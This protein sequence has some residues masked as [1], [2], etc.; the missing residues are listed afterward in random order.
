MR[1]K[2][3]TEALASGDAYHSRKENVHNWAANE[4]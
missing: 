3:K 1:A 2:I 4:V